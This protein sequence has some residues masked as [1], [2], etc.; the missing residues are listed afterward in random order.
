MDSIDDNEAIIVQGFETF[1]KCLWTNG[2]L[3]YAGVFHDPAEVL[4]SLEA[5][6]L[7]QCV[8]V[9]FAEKCIWKS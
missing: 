8:V 6:I 7:F 2:N 1:S 3:D 5:F 9:S 4:Y